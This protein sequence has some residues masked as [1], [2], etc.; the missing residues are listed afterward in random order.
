MAFFMFGITACSLTDSLDFGSQSSN[1]SEDAITD[2]GDDN[3]DENNGENASELETTDDLDLEDDNLP[4]R[5]PVKLV[6]HRGYSAIA[7]ENTIAAYTYAAQYGADMIELDVQMTSDNCIVIF[8]DNNMFRIIGKDSFV[9]DYTYDEIKAMSAGEWFNSESENH[10]GE[11]FIDYT[12]EKFPTLRESLE[13]AKSCGMGVDIEIKTL[14]PT[15]FNDW[16]CKWFV[17][18]VVN[19]V[20]EYDMADQVIF[21]SFNYDY[22]TQIENM[23]SDYYT[24]FIAD[25]NDIDLLVNSCNTDGVAIT[26]ANVCG[27]GQEDAIDRLHESGKEVYAWVI[28]DETQMK[29]LEKLGVDGIITN[30]VGL[31]QKVLK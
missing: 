31:G 1:S 25:M 13:L 21:S 4:D 15:L 14:N 2:E 5:E 17:T 10:V 16:E 11:I 26:Y 27:V 8:H 19:Q 30:D 9:G 22:L 28:D 24:M 23:N 6:G 18:Q 7:P 3:S 20:N 12:G 29:R